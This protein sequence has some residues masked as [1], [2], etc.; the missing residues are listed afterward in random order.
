MNAA[1][2]PDLTGRIV[3]FGEKEYDEGR[4]VANYYTSKDKYPKL[5]V[6]AQKAEDVQNAVKW[7]R[8]HNISLRIRSGGHNHEGY[9][10][11][12]DILLLDVGE[13]K[14]IQVDKSK[15]IAVVQPGVNNKELYT[16]LSKDGLTQWEELVQ[17]FR[18]PASY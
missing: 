8:C 12:N 9:S 11:G 16:R 13:M 4:L 1:N 7:A 6:Y 17:M 15:K 5:I 18:Y 10:T 3:K 14:D 2:C